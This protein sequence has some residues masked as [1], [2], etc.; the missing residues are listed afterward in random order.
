MIRERCCRDL[1]TYLENALAGARGGVISVK[2]GRVL[3]VGRAYAW[4]SHYAWC[5]SRVLRRYRFSIGMYV[6]TRQEAEEL[7]NNLDAHCEQLR[8]RQEKQERPAPPRAAPVA[9]DYEEKMPTIS[10][11]LPR[12]LLQTLDEYARERGLTRSDAIRMAI[13]QM[14]E[15]MHAA[16]EEAAKKEEAECAATP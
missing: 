3:A 11:H 14:F 16:A 12:A 8:R 4:K 10:F 7:L 13:L 2:L 1:R 5:L 9:I 6:L 15:K